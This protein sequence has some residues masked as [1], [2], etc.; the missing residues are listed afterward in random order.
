MYNNYISST[1][2]SAMDSLAIQRQRCFDNS[3][4]G[5]YTI[6][7]SGSP[8]QRHFTQKKPEHMYDGYSN[9]QDES[10]QFS[11]CIVDSPKVDLS[12]T[13]EEEDKKDITNDRLNLEMFV[14]AVMQ[15]STPIGGPYSAVEAN[16][17]RNAG[18][19]ASD[20]VFDDFCRAAQGAS[21]DISENYI[22]QGDIR[23]ADCSV[24]SD[25][26]HYVS[27]AGV[28]N[29]CSSTA[30]DSAYDA[31]DSPCLALSCFIIT[32]AIPISTAD[33]DDDVV[34]GN[35]TALVLVTLINHLP[36]Q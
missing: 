16:S 32:A 27:G 12:R 20:T 7:T 28:A 19:A 18:S 10:L 22:A 34:K 8:S 17:E 24:A 6:S 3:Y 33:E 26:A 9:V 25:A 2:L 11:E 30:D 29:S 5:I 4:E 15:D 21:N 13:F 35:K 36:N 31:S 1:G 23:K 14:A